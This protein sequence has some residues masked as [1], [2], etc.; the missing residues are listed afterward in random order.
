MILK[1]R[2]SDTGFYFEAI[3]IFWDTQR[4]VTLDINGEG[5]INW[6]CGDGSLLT[7]GARLSPFEQRVWV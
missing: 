1:P 5:S 6:L 7:H 4:G 3:D 2:S